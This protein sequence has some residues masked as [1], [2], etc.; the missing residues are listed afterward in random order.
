MMS[1]AMYS[2]WRPN[3]AVMLV[4]CVN[5]ASFLRLMRSLSMCAFH[6]R[7]IAFH[8]Y[9]LDL[10]MKNCKFISGRDKTDKMNTLLLFPPSPISKGRRKAGVPV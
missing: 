6:G 1:S 3:V 4:P 10:P 7:G 2:H 5:G 8:A 9:P